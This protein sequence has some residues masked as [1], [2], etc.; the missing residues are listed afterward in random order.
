MLLKSYLI[1]AIKN[2]HVLFH[3]MISPIHSAEF[4]KNEKLIGWDKINLSYYMIKSIASSKN[5]ECL[6][7]CQKLD[8]CEY[9]LIIANNCFLYENFDLDQF[10]VSQASSSNQSV[11]IKWRKVWKN[12][13]KL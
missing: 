12:I 9:A 8:A 13:Y 1:T 7:E 5:L 11:W 4:E 2:V 3:I 6:S 10:Q